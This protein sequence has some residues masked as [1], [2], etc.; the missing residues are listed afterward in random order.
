[1]SAKSSPKRLFPFDHVSLKYK[2][3]SQ[4]S[5]TDINFDVKRGET[6]GIIG[7][8]GSGKSSLVNMLP[9]FYDYTGGQLKIDGINVKDYAVDDLRNKIGVVMQKA[10]LFKGTIR[11]NLKWAIRMQAMPI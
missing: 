3:S 7:G 8:T 10:V 9:R 2:N 5:L 4:D 1:M 11:E 6:I